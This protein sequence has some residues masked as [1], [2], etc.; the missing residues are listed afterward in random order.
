MRILKQI[1]VSLLASAITVV[2]V[3]GGYTI[4]AKSYEFENN[5]SYFFVFNLYH[6]QMNE[7]FNE[8]MKS[9]NELLKSE[10][11][12]NDPAKKALIKPPANV[13][14]NKPGLVLEDVLTA[15]GDKNVS[16]YCVSMGALDMYLKY[17]KKLNELKNSL[18]GVEDQVLMSV[19][20]EGTRQQNED[21]EKEI[22]S[23]KKVMEAA[24]AAYSEYQLAYPMHRKYEEVL[25]KLIK[26]KLA[27]KDIRKRVA[28]F[29][30]KFIDSSTTDC[31]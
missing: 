1:I 20:L 27:L 26:Y 25:N 31:E 17:A 19:V 3:Y 2:L 11:F 13:K 9:L 29:P 24:V 16:R 7:Y 5:T 12:Y 18:K 6:K 22:A 23:S 14:P 4:Y 30:V 10:N 15:C 8:K 28:Q 21:I